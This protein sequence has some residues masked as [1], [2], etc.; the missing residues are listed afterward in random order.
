MY[1]IPLRKRTAGDTTVRTLSVD[2][3]IYPS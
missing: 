3:Y 1:A 2:P